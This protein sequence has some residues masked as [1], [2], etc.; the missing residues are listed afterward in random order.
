MKRIA[1]WAM[2]LLLIGALTTQGLAQAQQAQAQP[3]PK[4]N[5][6]KEFED[7]MVCYKEADH[8]KKAACSEKFVVDHKA[9][10]PIVMT[11]IFKYMLLGYANAGNWPKTFE[12]LDRQALAPKLTEAEKKQYNQIGLVAAA[13]SKNNPKTIE[14]AEK[15]LKDDPKNFQALVTLSGVLSAKS[16]VKTRWYQ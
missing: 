14:Y 13:N 2:P 10:D 11:E 12:T 7:Y 3:E 15:V 9:A 1:Y 4:W 6:N 16:Y 8:A 5:S